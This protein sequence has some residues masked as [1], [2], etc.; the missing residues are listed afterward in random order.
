MASIGRTLTTVARL[1]TAPIT[2]VTTMGSGHLVWKG[3]ITCNFPPV[4][5][6]ASIRARLHDYAPQFSG[7]RRV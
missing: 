1:A 6:R 2:I 7:M 3:A 4:M 5:A